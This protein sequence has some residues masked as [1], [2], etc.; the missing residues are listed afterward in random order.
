MN[1]TILTATNSTELKTSLTSFISDTHDI[2]NNGFKYRLQITII[3]LNRALE[4]AHISHSK[5]NYFLLF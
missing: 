5:V 3:T 4:R 2:L 1:N